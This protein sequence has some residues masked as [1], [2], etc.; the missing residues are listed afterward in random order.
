[1]YD[2]FDTKPSAGFG[3]KKPVRPD[4]N[5][6]VG[7]PVRSGRFDL[8]DDDRVTEMFYTG[9]TA[10]V[11]CCRKLIAG[12]FLACSEKNFCAMEIVTLRSVQN[13]LLK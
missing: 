5:R 8:C 2:R 7:H 11:N 6:S 3:I 12:F 9:S 10:L 13:Q 4:K 1:M